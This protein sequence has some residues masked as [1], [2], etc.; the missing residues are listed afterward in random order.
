MTLINKTPAADDSVPQWAVELPEIIALSV[1]GYVDD[2]T[3]ERHP[4]VYDLMLAHPDKMSE[5]SDRLLK[6]RAGDAEIEAMRVYEEAER[7]ALRAMHIDGLRAEVGRA[8]AAIRR[9]AL[10]AA[11]NIARLES[12]EVYDIDIAESPDM[13]YVKS[14]IDDIRKAGIAAYA[15]LPFDENG[16]AK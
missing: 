12:P 8:I 10:S 14:F 5:I 4:G 1:Y 9:E 3:S 11:A 7:E 13:G 2:K 6:G 16:D 15:I